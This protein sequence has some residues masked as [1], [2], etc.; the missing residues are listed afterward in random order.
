[1]GK[2]LRGITGLLLLTI[3]VTGAGTAAYGA[4]SSSVVEKVTITFKTVYGEPEEIPEPEI[5]SSGSGYSVGD[6]QFRTDYDKWKPGKKVRVEITLNAEDGKHFPVSLNRSDCKVT[7]ANF[8]SAK[9]LDDNSL[10]VKVDYIPVTVLGNT[11][12]AGWSNRSKKKAVWKKVEHAPGYTVTLYGD[13]KVVKRLNVESTN[14]DLSD[15]M[16][17]LDKTY[18][19][20][21]KA[22]PLTSEQ[23]KYLKEGS[24]VTSTD[25]EFDEDD[26]RK[27]ETNSANAD[28]GGSFKGN[29]YVM[30][31]GTRVVNTW[32]KNA[33][34]WYY[35]D[36]SGNKATGFINVEGKWYLMGQ[37][38]AMYIGWVYVNDNWYYM[39]PDG[40][41][42]T[43]WIQP[44]P[45]SWYHLNQSGIMERGWINVDGKW[46]FLAQDG[47]MQT[48]WVNDN[49]RWF[50]LNGDGSMAVNTTVDGWSIG[51]DGVAAR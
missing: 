9:A 18:Y 4:N 5:T 24:F 25:Q 47:K 37:D 1:M 10:Q 35:F 23:K 2:L 43:G 44:A 41:M 32:K 45:A 39:G 28:D 6:V 8:V 26:Y 38:G 36:G 34:K 42:Q 27:E 12:K 19:Y 46:Y 30:P 29:G 11:E 16:K 15:Y 49:N 14:V 17:D 22:V 13:D 7:G 33:G 50:Y 3:L 48:G 40:D 31:D 51:S 20:E 21:V